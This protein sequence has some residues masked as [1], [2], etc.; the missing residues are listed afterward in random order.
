MKMM[1][2]RKAENETGDAGKRE[3]RRD[4]WENTTMLQL[5]T[6]PALAAFALIPKVL[7]YR[8]LQCKSS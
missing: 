5:I 3:E 7:H 6:F 2:W 4:S 8:K 1:G